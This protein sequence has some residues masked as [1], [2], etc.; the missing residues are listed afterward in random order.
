MYHMPEPEDERYRYDM[1]DPPTG[2]K[3]H[4]SVHDDLPHFQKIFPRAYTVAK[5]KRCANHQPM[6]GYLKNRPF[7]TV[8]ASDFKYSRS[9][10]AFPIKN[11][12]HRRA[13]SASVVFKMIF[14][15]VTGPL[16]N[17][18]EKYAMVIVP[19]MV[20]KPLIIYAKAIVRLNQKRN[21]RQKTLNNPEIKGTR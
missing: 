4:K 7:T 11:F 10:N 1:Q 19:S 9:N 8:S 16:K 18:T 15:A 5:A 20:I 3:Q 2:F 17:T 6:L 12:P 21:G 13:I 14:A